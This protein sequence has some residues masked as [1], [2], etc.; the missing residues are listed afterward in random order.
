[1]EKNCKRTRKKFLWGE[2]LSLYPL[3]FAGFTKFK[4]NFAT[5]P[6]RNEAPYTSGYKFIVC[7]CVCARAY[8][9]IYMLTWTYT[10]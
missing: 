2:T 4:K 3:S 6:V 10:Q 9:Y 8:I 1:M 5:S 7:V